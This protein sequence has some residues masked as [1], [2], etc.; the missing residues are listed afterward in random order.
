MDTQKDLFVYLFVF[1]RHI[2]LKQMGL[3][4]GPFYRHEWEIRM[5]QIHYSFRNLLLHGS[6][7]SCMYHFRVVIRQP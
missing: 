6:T 1:F 4:D 5:A 2:S 3:S 7:A